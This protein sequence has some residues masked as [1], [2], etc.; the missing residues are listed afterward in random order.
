MVRADGTSH[1]VQDINIGLGLGRRALPRNMM[2][3][4]EAC[5][6]L[7]CGCGEDLMLPMYE[8]A[9]VTCPNECGGRAYYSNQTVTIE[10]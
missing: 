9:A 4:V 10:L 1:V 6:Y 2:P 8:G 5:H 7:K 3:P